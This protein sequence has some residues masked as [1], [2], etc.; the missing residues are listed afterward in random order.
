M[1]IKQ[2]EDLKFKKIFDSQAMN[3]NSKF[4]MIDGVFKFRNMIRIPDIFDLKQ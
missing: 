1:K 2:M 4:K 3:L